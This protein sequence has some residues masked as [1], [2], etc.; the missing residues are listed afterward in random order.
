MRCVL[1]GS[2]VCTLRN[3]HTLTVSTR[4]SKINAFQKHYAKNAKV[5]L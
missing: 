4:Q 2:E 3:D 5:F 1:E